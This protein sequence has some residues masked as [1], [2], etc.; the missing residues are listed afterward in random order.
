[1][2][3]A[4]F[5]AHHQRDRLFFAVF[6]VIGFF[7]IAMGFK[8]PI[9]ARYTGTPDYAAPLSLVVHVWSFFAWMGLLTLQVTLVRM[10]RLDLHRS[11][12][13]SLLALVPVMA[14]SGI[15]AEVYSQHFWAPREPE[16]IRFFIVPLLTI[17][18]FVVLA[19]FAY[20]QR[21]NASAHKR[22]ILLATTTLLIA[23]FSRW[24]GDGIEAVVGKGVLPTFL[25]EYG[26]A[27]LLI[28]VLIAYD[29]ATRGRVHRV[30]A[31][32]VPL[33]LAVQVAASLIYHSDWWPGL[34][35]AGLGIA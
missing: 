9:M 5:A 12:G 4:T 6:V 24:L 2:A 10:R 35:R 29:L 13:M 1:M 20:A 11:V 16:N 21:R 17:I 8:G 25:I 32:A 3:A 34:V 23:A 14:I 31:V 27:N 26:G 22:L 33:M 30:Y 28:L 18:S 7:A 15:A 19:G